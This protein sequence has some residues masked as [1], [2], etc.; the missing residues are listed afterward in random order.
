MHGIVNGKSGAPAKLYKNVQNCVFYRE[1]SI[2]LA[3]NLFF[4]QNTPVQSS[5]KY[6]EN[7]LC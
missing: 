3:C 4:L 6:K 7:A 5:V 2:E 1:K